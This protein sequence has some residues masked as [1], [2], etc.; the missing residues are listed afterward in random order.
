MSEKTRREFLKSGALGAVAGA[1]LASSL[2]LVNPKKAH[3]AA[4]HPFGYPVGGLDVEATR[5]LGYNSYKG[6]NGHGECAFGSFNAI[7]GQLAEVVGYPYDTIPTEMMEWAAGGVAGFG[8]FCGT[9]NGACAAIG[10]I[11]NKADALGFISDLLTWYSETALPT[12]IIA[13]TGDL[14][15][16]VAGGNL[17]HMSVTNWCLAS[18]FAS[19]S[20]ERSERCARLAGDVAAMTVSMLNNGRLGLVVPGDKTTCR[21]CH[22]KGTDY[23]AGQFTRGKMDCTICHVDLKKVPEAGH[24]K[25]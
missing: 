14:P 10:L 20:P 15:T 8:T 23:A 11:C 12:N 21:T 17:C 1:T 2:S 16:S 18:G 9:L 25:K 22:Y 3:A 24:H 5:Q 13:P 19:G 4:A 6:I 7:I